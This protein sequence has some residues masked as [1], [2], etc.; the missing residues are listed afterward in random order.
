MVPPVRARPGPQA[1]LESLKGAVARERHTR[2]AEQKRSAE[3]E[4]GLRSL[5]SRSGEVQEGLRS[6]QAAAEAAAKARD[7]A[8]AAAARHRQDSQAA[9][10]QLDAARQAQAGAE[11]EAGRLRER[12]ADME[13]SAALYIA[14][15]VSANRCVGR[16]HPG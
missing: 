15:E 13:G 11:Q 12:L 3:L 7:V 2:E 14:K 10:E 5:S 1:E 4:T 16:F 6:A 8:E 9:R